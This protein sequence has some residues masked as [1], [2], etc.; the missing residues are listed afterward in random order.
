MLSSN[1]SINHYKLP[2]GVFCGVVLSGVVVVPPAELSTLDLR[3]MGLN[4]GALG[5]DGS[6]GFICGGPGTISSIT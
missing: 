6:V 2:F 3:L 4:E 1:Q 5:N